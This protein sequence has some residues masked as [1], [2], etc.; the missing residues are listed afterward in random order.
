MSL[1]I[2]FRKHFQNPSSIHD[3]AEKDGNQKLGLPAAAKS[4]TTQLD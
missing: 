2:C 1:A 3:A 4:Q